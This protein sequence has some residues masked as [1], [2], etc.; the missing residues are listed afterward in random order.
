MS[1]WTGKYVIGL[2]GNIATGKSVICRMLGHL[3]AYTVDADVLSHRAISK[4]GPA[5]P[6]VVDFFGKFI[7]QPNGEIDRQ[8]LGR[9]V[10]SDS[11]ALAEL[12]KQIHPYVTQAVDILIKRS[13]QQV[14]VIE[15][16]KLLE[17]NLVQACDSVWVV[18]APERI[19]KE[20]L[21]IKR[22]MLEAEALQRIHA[23][24]SQKDKIAAADV[25]ITNTGSFSETWQQVVSAWEKIP[26]VAESPKIKELPV[27]TDEFNVIRGHPRDSSRIADFINQS[28]NGGDMVTETDVMN[29]FGDMA[30]L[31][32]QHG[33]SLVGLA[34]WQVEN[35]VARILH[36]Y[37]DKGIDKKMGL[38]CL[39]K[40]LERASTDLQCEASLVFLPAGEPNPDETW[41]E[42][43][44]K[45]K[46]INAMIVEA[47]KE[48]A[49]ESK[50]PG[51]I[52]LF[53]QLRED[54]VLHPI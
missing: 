41:L 37:L 10:F 47:W 49:I 17:G 2:T 9:I 1:N 3:G 26:V 33:N 5:Y 14:A 7:L 46:T 51:T 48:A 29:Q 54:R 28:H 6:A 35:L 38:T 30:F 18:F 50:P 20:R 42:L 13:R 25:I 27:D 36:V 19:Q 52:M 15:A 21:M 11:Q 22:G 53:K 16:I 32:L 43:G 39:I 8:K 4:D 34:A 24:A 12:E 40:E 45:P 31:L 23:Q 44:Y